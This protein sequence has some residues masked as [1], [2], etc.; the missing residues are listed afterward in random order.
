MPSLLL[1]QLGKISGPASP[2]WSLPA[3]LLHLGAGDMWKV[4]QPLEHGKPRQ[5]LHH[6]LPAAWHLVQRRGAWLGPYTQLPP[7]HALV[8]SL[9]VGPLPASVPLSVALSCPSSVCLIDQSRQQIQSVGQRSVDSR[10]RH[11]Y[12]NLGILKPYSWPSVSAD[13]TSLASMNRD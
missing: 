13:S 1:F 3:L 7:S 5:K 4:P 11:R 2:L 9:R 8:C 6:S 12:Q 10:T